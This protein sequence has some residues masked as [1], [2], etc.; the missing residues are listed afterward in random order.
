MTS[1][2]TIVSQLTHSTDT[3]LRS[4]SITALVR[5]EEQ[6]QVLKNVGIRSAVLEGGLD[7]AEGLTRLARQHD[8]VL[9]MAT[10]FHPPSA[11]A[12][13]RGLAMRKKDTGADPI[14]FQ[15]RTKNESKSGE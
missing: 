10:G 11:E 6:A 12:L 7:D 1:G 14:Y 15:V 2:G 13:I 5:S 4:L 3:T 8:A 9:H